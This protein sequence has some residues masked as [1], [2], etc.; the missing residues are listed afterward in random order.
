MLYA[1]NL[2]SA[3]LKGGLTNKINMKVILVLFLL[4]LTTKTFA[5]FNLNQLTGYINMSYD[6]LDEKLS[7]KG[8]TF[9]KTDTLEDN[10][11]L[12]TWKGKNNSRIG[13]MVT[14]DTVT[15]ISDGKYNGYA[16]VYKKSI[17]FFFTETKFYNTLLAEV[18]S[19]FKKIG[20]YTEG[21]TI[22]TIYENAKW[23]IRINKDVEKPGI[24]YTIKIDSKAYD[25]LESHFK[26]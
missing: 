7:K 23:I 11:T 8:F 21:T 24:F 17:G 1:T 13:F 26:F 3:K 16:D 9:Y 22:I 20:S 4:I 5:Q 25:I 14:P 12:A 6:S 15:L 10:S 2:H 18:K 19:K